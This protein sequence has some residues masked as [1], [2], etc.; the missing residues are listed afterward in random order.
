MTQLVRTS[1]FAGLFV[2]AASLF[3]VDIA[4]TQVVAGEKG[5]GK[6]KGKGKDII[7]VAVEAGKF[8]TLAKLLT[9]AGLVETLKGEGP[10]TVFAPTDDAFKKIESKLKDL[11]ADEVKSI[12]LSHVVVGKAVKAAEV[13]KELDGKEVNGYMVKVKGEKVTIANATVITP[14]VKASNGVIH[15]IDEVLIPAKK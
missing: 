14:D 4:A 13:I 1:L 2:F 9:D 15:V 7:E 5:K 6:G 12:L 8:K 11:K 3:V 10:F